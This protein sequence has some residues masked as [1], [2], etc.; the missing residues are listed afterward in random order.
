MLTKLLDQSHTAFVKCSELS[1]EGLI[2]SPERKFQKDLIFPRN[3]HII[4][5][6]MLKPFKRQLKRLPESELLDPI[7]KVNV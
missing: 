5:F 7:S 1:S 6:P 4:Y 3:V 2:I